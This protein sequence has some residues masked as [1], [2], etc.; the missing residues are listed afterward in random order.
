VGVGSGV[1]VAS[2]IVKLDGAACVP[3]LVKPIDRIEMIAA[4]HSAGINIVQTF[5]RTTS[6]LRLALLFALLLILWLRSL[7]LAFLQYHVKRDG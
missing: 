3:L 6:L 7:C 2:G 5:L 1:A 4:R